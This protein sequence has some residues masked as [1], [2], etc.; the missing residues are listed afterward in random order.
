MRFSTILPRTLR[1]YNADTRFFFPVGDPSRFDKNP[2]W[3]NEDY[4]NLIKRLSAKFETG[5]H[6][7]FKASGRSEMIDIEKQRLRTVIDKE[8]SI[9]RFHS[10]R[11]LIPQSFMDLQMAG[12]SEDYSMGYPEEPGFRA[13]IARSFYFYNVAADQ[14][15]TLRVVPF[16][17]MD[18]TLC[19]ITK[20]MTRQLRKLPFLN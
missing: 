18:S 11:F 16:Q 3:K 2:S 4:R 19:L 6:P 17:V 13:G 20:I 14:Q 1:K 15:T 7:S 12:I 8:I 5:L 9:S 10:I